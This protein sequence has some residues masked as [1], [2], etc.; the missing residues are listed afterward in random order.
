MRF[1]SLI[2]LSACATSAT[3]AHGPASPAYPPGLVNIGAEFA[4]VPFAQG[5]LAS[6][7]RAGA[8]ITFRLHATGQEPT[9]L[10]TEFLDPTAD[11]VTLRD[12]ATALDGSPL[13]EPKTATAAW[14]ELE[15]HAHFPRAATTISESDVEVPAGRF[16]AYEYRIAGNADG[17]PTVTTLWFAENLPG[18]PVK[19]IRQVGGETVFEM[20]LVSTHRPAAE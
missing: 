9:L 17:A 20:V 13:G 4:P 6:S 3:P 10:T 11:R 5:A 1:L 7:F 18:P 19:M 16:H 15:A 8:T 2:L 14:T 12:T